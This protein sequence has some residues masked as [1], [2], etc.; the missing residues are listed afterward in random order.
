MCR[1]GQHCHPRRFA[2][3]RSPGLGAGNRDIRQ[4]RRGRLRHHAAVGKPQRL[5]GILRQHQ[6][7]RRERFTSRLQ[8]DKAQTSAQHAG[9]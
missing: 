4:L 2:S 1:E 6:K 3:D 7:Q 8:A 9:G 5:S